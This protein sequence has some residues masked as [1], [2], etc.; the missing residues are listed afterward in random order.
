M[1]DENNLRFKELISDGQKFKELQQKMQVCKLRPLLFSDSNTS[2]LPNDLLYESTV[3]EKTKGTN[4]I[5]HTK[6]AFLR[7]FLETKL[8]ENCLFLLRVK[9]HIKR[10]HIS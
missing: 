5:F 3:V 7:D 9:Q 1:D 10:E 6:L 8:F 4:P 2:E